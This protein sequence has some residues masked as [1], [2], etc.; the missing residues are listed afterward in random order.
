[1]HSI[2]R[3]VTIL[4]TLDGDILWFLL[5]SFFLKPPEITP[6]PLPFQIGIPDTHNSILQ[7][8]LGPSPQKAHMLS[9]CV[10]S[11]FG[12]NCRGHVVR[13]WNHEMGE[14]WM[15]ERPPRVPELSPNFTQVRGTPLLH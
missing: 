1:M 8:F 13:Q 7:I 6:L 3:A 14:A 2:H 4:V 12:G 15:P 9:P 10:L 11:P 5:F